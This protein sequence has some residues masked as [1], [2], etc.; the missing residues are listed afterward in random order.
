MQINLLHKNMDK[1][2]SSLR[3]YLYLKDYLTLL[4]EVKLNA[5]GLNQQLQTVTSSVN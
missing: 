3:L 4:G 5:E 2:K 1:T